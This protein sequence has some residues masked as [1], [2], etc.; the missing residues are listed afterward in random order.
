MILQVKVFNMNN[1]CFKGLVGYLTIVKKSPDLHTCHLHYYTYNG[2][3]PANPFPV[4]TV[5]ATQNGYRIIKDKKQLNP[6]PEC[7]TYDEVKKVQDSSDNYHVDV[8]EY[9]DCQYVLT[10]RDNLQLYVSAFTKILERILDEHSDFNTIY[11]NGKNQKLDKFPAFVSNYLKNPPKDEE[12]RVIPSE[13]DLD[14]MRYLESLFQSLKDNNLSMKWTHFDEKDVSLFNI[15][16]EHPLLFNSDVIERRFKM[17]NETSR[18]IVTTREDFKAVLNGSDDG[19]HPFLKCNKIYMDYPNESGFRHANGIYLVGNPGDLP[20]KDKDNPYSPKSEQHIGKLVSDMMLGV[21]DVG[22]NDTTLDTVE[23]VQDDVLKYWQKHNNFIYHIDTN[24]LQFKKPYQHVR[25]YGKG[26][27]VPCDTKQSHLSLVDGR[28]LT[29]VA[30]PLWLA[31]SNLE[32]APLI[33]RVRVDMVNNH[34]SSYIVQDITEAFYQTKSVPVGEEKISV[35]KGLNGK[36]DERF[37]TVTL[38][39]RCPTTGRVIDFN[40]RLLYNIEMPKINVMK[41]L[42]KL[43]PVIKLVAWHSTGDLYRYGIFI[44]LHQKTLNKNSEGEH[45]YVQT[46]NAFFTSPTSSQF[47]I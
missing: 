12:G 27:I 2:N 17:F 36:E 9:K 30:I 32:R 10:D 39:G 25:V 4:P 37:I 11:Y 28:D 15:Y 42:S 33:N 38:Q 47:F 29:Y 34:T 14:K 46:E 6:Y 31:Q 44:Q 20:K 41:Q 45:L 21:V 43:N 22:T 7:N 3:K 1:E 35:G 18:E 24:N 16:N 5:Y 23:K 26:V 13:E 40:L 8:T 19:I